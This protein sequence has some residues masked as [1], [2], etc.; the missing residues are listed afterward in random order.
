MNYWTVPATSSYLDICSKLRLDAL[1]VKHKHF[2]A[3]ELT[4]Y[5][6]VEDWRLQHE[7]VGKHFRSCWIFGLKSHFGGV[8]PGNAQYSNIGYSKHIAG[9]KP[10]LRDHEN[11]GE[12]NNLAVGDEWHVD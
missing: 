6:E 7:A 9:R 5:N 11:V 2:E 1:W 12:S 10:D 4:Y 8:W 3:P